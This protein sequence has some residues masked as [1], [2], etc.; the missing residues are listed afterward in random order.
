MKKSHAL[1]EGGITPPQLPHGSAAAFWADGQVNA[2]DR[3][4]QF[5]HGQSGITLPES[6]A[7]LDPEDHFQV[8]GLH[9]VI[10]EPVVPDLLETGREH[11]LKETADKLFVG[12]DDLPFGI[13]GFLSP[14]REN[15]F[16]FCNREDPAV[17][18]GDPVSVTAKVFDGIAKA[19]KS[20]F[21]VRAPVFPIKV[22]FECLPDAG[23]L[24]GA[25]GGRKNKLPLLV[26]GVQEGKIFSLKLIPEYSDRDK[27]FG[28]GFT[29]PAA[30]G[31]ASA[32]DDAVHM[33]MV[34]QFLVPGMEDLDDP[35]LGAEIFLVR[36]KFQESFRTAFMEQ[37]VKAFLVGINQ[38]I[39]FMGEGKHHM[40][41]GGVND[42]R[43]AF[44]HPDFFEDCLAAGTV[45]V[46]A[47]IIMELHAAAFGACTDID[48]E[49]AGFAGKD[50]TGSFLLLI[51]LEL[52]GLA[53]LPIRIQPYFLNFEVTHGR[54]LPSGQK[55]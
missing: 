13:T 39:E 49:A 4:E 21:D 9:P 41:V 28:G 34:I 14:C 23:I 18:D 47:G 52:S 15:D 50:G 35:R 29:D 24:Q 22:V 10:E 44:I 1:W 6:L 27:K 51:G 45:P 17:G 31:K 53:E 42:F 16:F 19:V 40:E 48:A 46:P 7:A 54:H 12:E 32:G 55:G 36:A 33:D 20:L 38:G 2:P 11:M 26:A 25:E 8:S 37:A 30:R 43:P 3:L 5:F